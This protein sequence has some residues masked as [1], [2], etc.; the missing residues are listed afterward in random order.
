MKSTREIVNDCATAIHQEV[1]KPIGFKKSGFNW[2]FAD[3]WTRIINLQLSRW[4]SADDVQFTLNFGVFIPE[5]HRLSERPCGDPPLK[6]PDCVVRARYGQLTPSRLDHWWK[7]DAKTDSAD[8]IRDVTG[9]LVTYGLPWL[10]SLVGYPSVAFEYDRQKDLFMAGLAY[11]L[12]GQQLLA[13][14]RMKIAIERANS[15]F[16]PRAIRIADQLNLIE[17]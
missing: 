17:K 13:T 1:L 2:T 10:N 14:E 12:A 5:L 6:E 11:H 8:L 4:N 15:H 16:R 3:E 9:A 7:V